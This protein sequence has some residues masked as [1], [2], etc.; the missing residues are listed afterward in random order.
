M[1]QNSIRIRFLSSL[2]TNF[3]KMGVS[4]LAGIIIAKQLGPGGY[5]AYNFL[6]GSF[7]ALANLLD[8]GTSGAF[9]T[10]IS[11]RTRSSRFFVYYILW[12]AFQL[13][14]LLLII[15]LLPD[16]LALK[17]WLG[18]KKELIVLACLSSFSLNQIWRL[19]GQIGESIAETVEVQVR[20]FLA[21]LLYLIGISMMLRFN[22]INLKS[23]FIFS[24]ILYFAISFL[25]GW[26]LYFQQS[27]FN[28]K[29]EDFNT[30]LTEF[31]QFCLPLVPFTLIEFVHSFLDNWLLQRLGGAVQQ[32]Y[33]AVGAR[34]SSFALIATNSILMIFWRE[35]AREYEVKNIEKVR[36]LYFQACRS[37]YFF[38]SV[39][40]FSLLPF[41]KL[42][43][44]TLLGPSYEDS[45]LVLCLMFLFP[46][47][48]CLGRIGSSMLLALHKTQTAANIGIIFTL[49][50]MATTYF[51]MAPKSA[52]LP[53]LGLGALG[54]AWKMLLC[55]IIETSL[56]MIYIAKYIRSRFDVLHQIYLPIILC[57]TAFS[58]KSGINLLGLFS[59][60]ISLGII[61]FGLLYT[62][63]T[64]ALIYYFPSIIGIN[65]EKLKSI[66]LRFQIYKK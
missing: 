6:L 32:G 34:F 9:F 8:V 38:S 24:A 30:I 5:G 22:F 14:V 53:G 25:Y 23:L 66:L 28:S 55:Q 29:K 60:S 27:F 39:I 3:F 45:W 58:I 13:L 46:L 20:N 19:T 21:S 42:I 7:S 36:Q 10:F 64:I 61:V 56:K 18:Y 16:N 63:F 52:Q 12:V 62:L 2:I 4:F 11:A 57:T 48:Q 26:K 65:Q 51:F 35:V 40:G 59:A 50:S 31:G 47:H 15:F 33:Y 41:S 43:V 17:I 49:I 37:L 44:S 1:A 54:F